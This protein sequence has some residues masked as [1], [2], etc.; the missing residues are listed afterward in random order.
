MQFEAAQAKP[1]NAMAALGAAQTT[2]TITGSTHIK[3]GRR[4]HSLN[5]KEVGEFICLLR[6]YIEI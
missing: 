1:T 6:Q 3:Q 4:Q 5:E 2:Q